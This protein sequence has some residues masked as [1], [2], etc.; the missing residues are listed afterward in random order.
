MF[1]AMRSAWSAMVRARSG[2]VVASAR[3]MRWGMN[4][5][6]WTVGG[7]S[8]TDFVRHTRAYSLT[9]IAHLIKAAAPILDAKEDH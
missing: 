9:D 6:R 3:A 1:A 4:H 8:Y 7:A 2:L 5:G